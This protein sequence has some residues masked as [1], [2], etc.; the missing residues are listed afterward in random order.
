MKSIIIDGKE[1]FFLKEIGRGGFGVVYQIQMEGQFYALKRIQKRSTNS[2]EKELRELN[3][4]R[5]LNHPNFVKCYESLISSKYICFLMEY[6]P[7]GDLHNLINN[8]NG[9]LFTEEFCLSILKQLANGLEYLHNKNFIH[10][11]IKPNNILIKED[12][13]VKYA[14]FGTARSLTENNYG[15]TFAGTKLYMASEVIKGGY[16]QAV[17]VYSLGCVMYE[18]CTLHPTFDLY[19]KSTKKHEKEKFTPLQFDYYDSELIQLIFSMF[20]YSPEKRPTAKQ[21]VD[22]MN[23]KRFEIKIERFEKLFKESNLS[24]I[25]YLQE[26]IDQCETREIK[27]VK[28]NEELDDREGYCYHNYTFQLSPLKE[29]NENE[30]NQTIEKKRKYKKKNQLIQ[31]R[32]KMKNFIVEKIMKT[33]FIIRIGDPFKHPKELFLYILSNYSFRKRSFSLNYFSLEM[34]SFRLKKYKNCFNI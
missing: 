6:L 34:K 1:A 5:Q 29:E 11:D 9:H 18:L 30:T 15:M 33:T 13:T 22:L 2:N 7:C 25:D 10:R 26:E 21:I 20:Q 28:I 8:R 16:N 31:N 14:D 4:W 12:G 24:I 23:E 17:D 19:L 32:I 3:V 27:R